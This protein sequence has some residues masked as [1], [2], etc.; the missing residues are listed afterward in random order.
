MRRGVKIMV[1]VTLGMAA[2]ILNPWFGVTQGVH[3]EYGAP[4]MRAAIEGTWRLTLTP[5]GEPPREIVFRV[6]QGAAASQLHASRHALVRAAAA[7]GHRALVRTA[8]ACL[9]TSEMPLEITVLAGGTAA[10][11]GA[12]GVFRV[13]TPRFITGDLDA[14][15]ADVI[16]FARITPTGQVSDVTAGSLAPM[17]H[18]ASPEARH[19]TAENIQPATLQR[20]ER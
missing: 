11:N 1:A 5:N 4:E 7:C 3:Y 10:G 19:L 13:I 15:V 9:D 6:A 16:V 14:Q 2:L 17:G 12:R 20:I 18:E 8:G